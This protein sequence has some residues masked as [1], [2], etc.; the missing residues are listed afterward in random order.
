[1]TYD[2]TLSYLYDSMPVFHQVGAAAYK[3]GLAT[4]NT[5]D[6]YLGYPHRSYRTIHV[7]GTNGKGS[8]SH[9]IASIL[10][11]SGYKVGLYTSPHLVDFR[12]RI[13]VNGQKTDSAYVIDF[14]ARHHTFFETLKPSFFELTSSM[15]FDYFRREKVDFAIIEVGLGGRLDSTNIITPILSV[16]TN[17]SLEHTLLLGNTLAKI[18][19]EKAGIIKKGVPVVI[20]EAPDPNVREVFREKAGT[21][22]APIIWAEESDVLQEAK[23]KENGKWL[24]RTA[25]FGELEGEL[26]GNVQKKNAQTVLTALRTLI[27]G[28]ITIPPEAVHTGFARVAE[29]SGLMGRWQTLQ[30]QPHVICDTGHNIGAWEYLALQLKQALQSYKQVHIIIG[31]ANDKDID[32][33]LALTPKKATYYFTQASVRRAFPVGDFAA[34]ARNHG[35]Q[36][37]EYL[38]VPEAVNS[39]LSAANEDDL[40]FIGGSTFVVA[41]ALPL[42][43]S[44]L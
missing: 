12:E 34:K 39:A 31:M 41:D 23:V 26:G 20:G 19:G 32:G 9:L 28:K 42:F 43:P 16:I 22:Q 7:G 8:V 24:F 40:I 25:D 38:T 17:I 10:Q 3:P 4:S 5:L 27:E 6:E 18:A 11:A 2:E 21:M 36:G 29:L 1:M 15:A 35:L 44:E 13:R 14:V 30:E 37:T 33:V